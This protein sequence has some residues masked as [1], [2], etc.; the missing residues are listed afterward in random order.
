[1]WCS[2]FAGVGTTPI[3]FVLGVAASALAYGLMNF[4]ADASP[5]RQMQSIASVVTAL[6]VDLLWMTCWIGLIL[7]W[8]GR[9]GWPLLIIGS[10][11]A[12]WTPWLMAQATS[13]ESFALV[14]LGM[15][16]Q[17]GPLNVVFC[18]ALCA[19]PVAVL[20]LFARVLRGW[21]RETQR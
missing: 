19:V 7:I 15:G 18:G 3:F 10:V 20:A 13:V 16:G 2:P 5:S 8:T 17:T 9:G 11:A 1:L 4:T 14:M 6:L 12:M 21:A